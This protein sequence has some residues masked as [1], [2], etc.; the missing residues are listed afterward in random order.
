MENLTRVLVVDNNENITAKI[1]K[2][3]SSHAVIKVVK[4]INNGADAL[5][6]IINHK[7]EYDIICMDIILP[8]V[9]GL[10]ILERMK[11]ANIRKKVIVL[12]SYKKEYTINMT[13]QYGVSYY[14]LKPF[15]MLALESRIIELAKRVNF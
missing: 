13:N 10:T 9:D 7:H 11:E 8:E 6:Y 14:M 5:D 12:T 2:Q 1:E 3:F 15:S 4:V